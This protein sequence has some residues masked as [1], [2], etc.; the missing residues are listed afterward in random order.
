M[1]PIITEFQSEG[2][3]LSNVQMYPNSNKEFEEE[4]EKTKETLALEGSLST[5]DSFLALHP[6][7]PGLIPGIPKNFFEEL[8]PKNYSFMMLPRLIDSAAA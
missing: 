7:A 8:F 4:R 6:A 2:A 1:L 3:I 5:I